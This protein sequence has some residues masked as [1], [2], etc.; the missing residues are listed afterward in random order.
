[1]GIGNSKRRKSA[2]TS[3][4]KEKAP[5]NA[6]DSQATQQSPRPDQRT[7]AS[8]NHTSVVS[9]DM[10][11]TPSPTLEGTSF[12]TAGTA[13]LFVR[14][15]EGSPSAS[16]S[17]MLPVSDQKENHTALGNSPSKVFAVVPA[18]HSNQTVPSL[19]YSQSPSRPLVSKYVVTPK[20][21]PR[22]RFNSDADLHRTTNCKQYDPLLMLSSSFSPAQRS[23]LMN[24]AVA[25]GSA[26]PATNTDASLD[27]VSMPKPLKGILRHT[28][29]VGS[30]PEAR[31]RGL[32]LIM[33][34]A[35]QVNS[36][37]RPSKN[38]QF[39]TDES[40]VLVFQPYSPP[41]MSATGSAGVDIFQ[42]ER[43]PSP[44]FYPSVPLY[45]VYADD[46]SSEDEDMTEDERTMIQRKF[47]GVLVPSGR[48]FVPL[49][50]PPAII[51]NAVCPD[52][53]G[54]RDVDDNDDDEHH[55]VME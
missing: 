3:P 41:S 22:S 7:P 46:S 15:T 36:P 49:L 8:T 9:F 20:I 37:A 2:G 11:E 6:K 13:D 51:P 10:V 4:I 24:R 53:P 39:G 18:N 23:V 33:R 5:L 31:R 42:S 29:T 12:P 32:S 14:R 45:N 50:F 44:A 38:V 21:M 17:P 16:A 40:R 47:G 1:M 25:E 48:G 30:L 35:P 34:A 28:S 52:R 55:F 43:S 19:S 26:S 27:S 54:D